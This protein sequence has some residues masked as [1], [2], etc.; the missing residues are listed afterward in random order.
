MSRTKVGADGARG[1]VGGLQS[2]PI[3]IVSQTVTKDQHY[4]CLP[5][6]MHSHV[7]QQ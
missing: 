5:G 2:L 6:G 3:I 7:T 4:P 1:R